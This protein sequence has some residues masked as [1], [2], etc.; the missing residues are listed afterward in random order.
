M[1]E[2]KGGLPL[3]SVNMK[4]FLNKIVIVTIWLHEISQISIR[5]GGLCLNY[6]WE[7]VCIHKLLIPSK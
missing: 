7:T 2:V 3:T 1:K 5:I 4:E 6:E